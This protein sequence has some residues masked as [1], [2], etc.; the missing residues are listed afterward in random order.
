MNRRALT[1]AL[2]AASLAITMSG[3]MGRSDTQAAAVTEVNISTLEVAADPQAAA[4][5]I[6]ATVENCKN[7]KLDAAGLGS[8]YNISSVDTE[9][10]LVYRTDP[11]SK[12]CDLAIILPKEDKRDRIRESLQLYKEK[13]M[14]EFKDYD[15]FDAH[16]IAEGAVIYDQGDYL[17]M[18]MLPD[19]ESAQE[20]INA[21]IPQ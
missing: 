14:A 20:L 10:F 15:L 18:L 7:E 11:A 2:A 6:Y 1:L 5:A 21:H 3:C 8:F 16:K 9:Q 12:L 13:R 19:N 4:D 17:V